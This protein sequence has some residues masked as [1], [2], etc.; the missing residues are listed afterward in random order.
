MATAITYTTHSAVLLLTPGKE[1][2][3]PQG[4][5]I[6]CPQHK[7]ALSQKLWTPSPSTGPHLFL[8]VLPISGLES[9][10]KLVNGRFLGYLLRDS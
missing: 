10:G 5:V 6:R 1:A 2:G 8:L 7:W 4:S 3:S 9:L